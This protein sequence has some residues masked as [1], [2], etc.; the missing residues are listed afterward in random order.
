M[1]KRAKPASTTP[2]AKLSSVIKSAR[3]TMR[4]DAGLNGDLDRIPQL[5]WLL[6]LKAYDGLEE[7]REVT[8]RKFR[9]AIEKPY[10]WREWAADSVN[11]LTGDELLQFVNGKLLPY[12]RELRG[13]RQDDPRDVIAAVFKETHNRMLSGYLLRDVVNKVDEVNFKSSDDIHTMAHFYESMLREMRDAAGDS[14]EFYTPRPVIRFMVQQIDPLLGETILDPACGTGGFLVESLEHV[15]P[16][17]KNVEELRALDSDV[18]GIEKKPL[19]YL[20]GMMNL[21][22]HEVQQPHI[23]RD[24]ALA[25]PVTDIRA[26][27]RVDVVLTN[28]PFGGEEEKGIQSNFPEAT[29]TAETAW[30]FLQLV[31]RILRSGGRCGIVL[32][33]GVLFGQGTGARIK[34]RLLAECDLHTVVRL[35]PGVFTPYTPIPSNLLFFDKSGRT[36]DVWFYEISPPEGRKGYTKTKPLRF[37]EF[38]DCSAWWGGKDRKGRK[39]TSQAWRIPIADLEANGFNLD[40]RN[41]N[42]PDELAHRPP[43]DL[44]NE[45]RQKQAE[46]FKAL[47]EIETEL[48]ANR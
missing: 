3:D 30:L 9:P 40:L 13:T 12:L 45:L 27:D 47:E 6:F 16:H 19:P 18:R 33:N 25:R 10:R 24:N 46:I 32:P 21:L 26:T 4:K 2:Q 8:E 42:R 1:P 37:E 48:A 39:E 43:Q 11:G 23:V 15:R 7:R 29:R 17:V 35:P 28:P 41:P 22:L 36:K 14:G 38:A 20:L 44:V 5:A 31:Q 34:E